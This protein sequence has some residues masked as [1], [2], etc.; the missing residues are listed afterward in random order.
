LLQRRLQIGLGLADGRLQ[1]TAADRQA[2]G[3]LAPEGHLL[4]GALDVAAHPV[5]LAVVRFEALVEQLQAAAAA[6]ARR[7]PRLAVALGGL[8]L[9]LRAVEALL[10]RPV[11]LLGRGEVFEDLS[12]ALVDPLQLAQDRV[13]LAAQRLALGGEA[14]MAG[15][16]VLL[17]RPADRELLAE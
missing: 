2:L 4:A 3:V 6:R 7:A 10:D 9:G 16:Q 12:T 14:A 1:L 15:R 11:T 5:L 8:Q 13:L 17:A